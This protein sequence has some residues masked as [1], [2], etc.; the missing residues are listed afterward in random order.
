VT[1]ECPVFFA[2]GGNDLFGILAHPDASPAEDLA[3]VILP[4]AVPG[5]MGGENA[6][7]VRL[8]RAVTDLGWASFRFDYRGV[9][10]STGPLPMLRRDDP[11]LADLDAALGWLGTEGYR[12]FV[13]VGSC[14]GAQTALLAVPGRPDVCGAALLSCLFA[15]SDEAL[16]PPSPATLA[17]TRDAAARGLDLLFCYGREDPVYAEFNAARPLGLEDLL[18]SDHVEV[19]LIDGEIHSFRDVN[20]QPWVIE[21]VASW[22]HGVA[23][24]LAL[25]T[26]NVVELGA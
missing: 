9:G 11:G 12:R 8:A 10:D 22:V 14:F 5:G 19:A 24:R 1:P 6:V 2:S 26:P 20:L 7:L 15:A 3:V 23:S 25:P 16:V 17:A 21:T 4:E 18:R 13:L